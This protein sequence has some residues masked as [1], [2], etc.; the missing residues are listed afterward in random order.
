[1]EQQKLGLLA[2]VFACVFICPAG[3]VWFWYLVRSSS[4]WCMLQS[5]DTQ[6][7]QTCI[8]LAQLCSIV[9]VD[10][11]A[12][13]ASESAGCCLLTKDNNIILLQETFL[14]HLP[15][16]RTAKEFGFFSSFVPARGSAGK[17]SDGLAAL[18]KQAAPLQRMEPNVHWNAGRWAHYL[19]LFE[20]ARLC[21]GLTRQIRLISGPL[22]VPSSARCTAKG[23][24]KER[25]APSW[26]VPPVAAACRVRDGW[27]WRSSLSLASSQTK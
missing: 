22:T 20:G 4:T 19:L 3:G 9:G 7:L 27:T 8:P 18:C 15:A 12:P 2:C 21:A 14:L 1:M 23:S 13:A 5:L 26:C 6:A 17:T 10:I 16:L 11:P 25:C 24:H